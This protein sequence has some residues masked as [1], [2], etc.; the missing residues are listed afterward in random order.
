[1]AGWYCATYGGV[2]TFQQLSLF[3]GTAWDSL[4]AQVSPG[5]G[6]ATDQELATS[7]LAIQLNPSTNRRGP[8]SHSQV[9]QKLASCSASSQP[10]AVQRGAV[11]DW[12]LKYPRWQEPL[13]AAI[14]EFDPQQLPAK[15][16]RAEQAIG[17]R[18]QELAIEQDNPEEL[19]L[20]SDGLS[21]IVDLKERLA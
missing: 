18:L 9:T 17:S 11:M 5:S 4:T 8:S 12:K 15:L 20:L 13:A 3:L 10:P 14:L 21:I 19:R 16:Q 7:Q 1:M 6:I 2:V